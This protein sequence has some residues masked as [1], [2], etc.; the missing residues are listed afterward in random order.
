MRTKICLALLAATACGATLAIGQLASSQALAQQPAGAAPV[1]FRDTKQRYSYAM[2]FDMARNAKDHVDTEMLIRGIRDGVSGKGA[3]TEQELQDAAAAFQQVLMAEQQKA[4]QTMGEKMKQEGDAFLAA[5][6]AKPGVTT[7]PDGLQYKVLKQ[8]NGPSPKPTDTITV[9][10]TGTLTNGA[11]FD[12][13][14]DRGQPLTMPVNKAIKGWIE[15]L[16]MMK[17]GDKWQLV[18]PPDLGYGAAGAP[19]FIPPNAVLVFEVE[20]LGIQ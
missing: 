12:S 19:P 4:T 6:K 8:G 16:P 14:I 10:Y 11:K 5:N 2:G 17:V 15:A 9:D 13:S 20:L 18:I 7:L 1:E 3:M